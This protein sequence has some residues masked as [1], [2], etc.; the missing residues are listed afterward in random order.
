MVLPPFGLER[1][2]E[3]GRASGWGVERGGDEQW[4]RAGRCAAIDGA[5]ER[6]CGANRRC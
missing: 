6:A 3:R 2:V 1:P 5:D 4:G